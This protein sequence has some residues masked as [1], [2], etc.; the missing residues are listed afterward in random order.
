[1]AMALLE[2][3][4]PVLVLAN[5]TYERAARLVAVLQGYFPQAQ[6]RAVPLAEAADV[7][8]QSGLLINATSVGLHDA[9]AALL[10]DTC[11]HPDQVVYDLV[12]RPLYTSLLQAAQ[13]C[14]AT[15]VPGLDM[16]IGQGAA[17]FQIWTGMPLP[18]EAVRRLL[19]PFFTTAP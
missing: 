16:L 19:Q 17:A 13:R 2:A 7:A 6:V 12:Y 8:R 15:I 18:V 14:G 3:G 9:S 11:F 4:C 10:P 1:V 5:R